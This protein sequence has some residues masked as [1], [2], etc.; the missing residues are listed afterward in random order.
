MSDAKIWMPL[1]IGDYLAD[2]SR[3]TTEQ[4][5]AYILI[6]MDY[7]RN[8]PPPD[9][10]IALSSITRMQLQAWKRIRE[11]MLRMFRIDGGYWVHKR[12]EEERA[13]A[14]GNAVKYTNRAKKAA[15]KRWGKES[16]EDATSIAQG[17]LLDCTSPSPSPALTSPTKKLKKQSSGYT[18]EFEDV[19]KLYPWTSDA[20]KRVAFKAWTAR[21][22]AGIQ[23]GDITEGVKRY[24]AYC[25]SLEIEQRYIKQPATF[26]GPDEHYL[27]AW[28]PTR[29]NAPMKVSRMNEM[30]LDQTP[31]EYAQGFEDLG[32][33][34]AR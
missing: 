32:F 13:S 2:T 30:G 8:G 21:L 4:H 5:G 16:N 18:P 9:D 6:I 17:L 12:I 26:F 34:V 10:D 14:M 15:A 25:R 28:E 31:G 24:A 1:Y 27:Q 20:N 19:W 22:N 11:A 3:L 29:P 23:P 7:W 33:Q